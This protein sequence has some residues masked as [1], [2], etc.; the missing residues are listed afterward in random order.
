[1]ALLRFVPH[2]MQD[3]AG[4]MRGQLEE[5]GSV[6]FR[7][8]RPTCRPTPVVPDLDFSNN[9]IHVELHWNICRWSGNSGRFS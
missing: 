5:R 8:K 9:Y 1:M 2:D 6:W 4:V 3:I 7:Q